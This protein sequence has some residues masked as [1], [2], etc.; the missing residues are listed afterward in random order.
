M[1]EA[2]RAAIALTREE[3]QARML[4]L[5]A[6]IGAAR[7]REEDR[8]ESDAR[9]DAERRQLVGPRLPRQQ[10]E[11]CRRCAERL[12]VSLYRFAADA[13]ER[14]CERVERMFDPIAPQGVVPGTGE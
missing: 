12:G 6:N 11:R 7:G 9:T 4:R 1:R 5:L 8:A 3:E 14:E 13:L 2:M 10:A